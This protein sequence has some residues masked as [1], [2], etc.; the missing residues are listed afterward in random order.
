MVMIRATGQIEMVNAQAEWVFGYSRDELLGKPVEMLVPARFRGHHPDL[1]RSFFDEPQSRPMGAGRDLY[2]LRKDGSEFPVEIGLNPI[3]TEEGTMVLSAVVDISDR[4]RK[5]ES[6]QAALREI[7][8]DLSENRGLLEAAPDA[9]V[10]VNQ[11]GEIV[12]LNIR[13]EKEFGYRRDEL[14]GQKVR[15]IIP[16]GFAEQLIADGTRTAEDAL[17]HRIGTGI[18]LTGRRKDGSE[19]PIE[20][21]LSP[22]E[23]AEETLVTAAIRDISVRKAAEKQLAQMEGRYRGLLEAAPDAM[24]VVNQGGEIVLLNIRAEKDFG[25][26]RDELLGQKVKNIIPEGFAER[27]V[28]DGTRTAED[29]LA[30]R[31][32]TGFELTGRRKD[33]SEF[34][35]E[36]MLSPLESAEGIQVT[37]AIRD[38]SVRKA[39]EK[40]LAQIEGTARKAAQA[41][42]AEESH[43]RDEA[44]RANQAKSDFLAN[45]SHEIRTPMNGIIGMTDLLLRTHLDAWQ[46]RFADAVL[47]SSE[48]LLKL[49]NNV[50]DISKLESGKVELEEIDFRLADCID[51]L[52]ALLE[53]L[54]EKKQLSL[55]A[56]MDQI[57]RTVLKGDCS[58]LR[59]VL[60]NLLSNALKFTDHGA[61]TLKVSGREVGQDRVALRIEV[62]DTGCGFD[63]TVRNK[64]FL[65]FQQA[66]VSIARKFGGSGL[67]L[68]LCKQIIA[69]MGGEVGAE[70]EPGKGSLFWVDVTLPLGSEQAIMPEAGRNALAGLRVLVVD[71]SNVDLTVFAQ[72][73]T[74]EGLIVVT[75]ADA[76]SAIGL[77]DEA[78]R[79]GRLFDVVV[80]K[81]HMSNAT[82]PELARILRSRLGARVPPMVL[83][84][85]L[86]VMS[87]SDP[88]RALFK[89]CLSKPLRGPELIAC[90]VRVLLPLAQA[91]PSPPASA[92]RVNS[93]RALFV[94]DNEVNRLLGM[95]LLEHAG[96]AVETAEDGLQ[97][98]EAVKRGSFGVIFMDVQM[99]NMNGIEATKAIRILPD[100]RGAVPIVAVTANAMVGD[101]EDYLRAGMNDYVSKPL[102]A[103]QFL[104]MALKWTGSAE[105]PTQSQDTT[106]STPAEDFDAISLL[107]EVVLGRLHP[108]IPAAKFQAVIQSYLD[109]DFLA[110]IEES[111]VAHDLQALGQI[112]HTCMG[113]SANLGA[114]RLRAI[115]EAL[116]LA[117]RAKNASVVS[118]LLPEMRRVTNLTHIALR[119]TARL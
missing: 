114:S 83:M 63:A 74:D 117:C 80:M 62:R 75:A 30:Q 25:Y 81:H 44:D 16:E 79:S 57:A 108:I 93:T 55:S 91:S 50:L 11:G 113:T 56:E 53:P 100:G 77:V 39:A 38:I 88:D 92:S 7:S 107:D 52:L 89:A 96:Y 23:N 17:A 119:S 111:A 67:G 41:A 10:V 98:I 105:A 49:I 72:H 42:L 54:A 59:Q 27:L 6:I 31:I 73:L 97:A 15:N 116:E 112:A 26:R 110:G 58:R 76:Q 86:G 3:E 95:T 102:N 4:K 90:L 28:A 19:F 51:Q 64:L 9:M 14:L 66:D 5:D 82:G 84:S 29:A 18:E 36:I 68:A 103:H 8:R 32:G 69:L 118:R 85:T 71:D 24:V 99:P 43:L 109:T 21:M 2:G 37:A 48:T 61:V 33:G 46:R 47:L 60:Q 65:K 40:H 12:L 94:D 87:K 78:A 22:L 106:T 70:S 101:R 35:I 1:R 45:M 115:A 13:A 20:I 104:S 34:P